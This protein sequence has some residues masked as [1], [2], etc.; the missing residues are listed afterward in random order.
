MD[1]AVAIVQAYLHLNG[2]FTVTEY[3]IIESLTGDNYRMAT[4]IDIMAFRFPGAG[5]QLIGKSARRNQFTTEPELHCPLDVPYMIIAEVKEGHAELNRGATNPKVLGAA[6]SRFGC[7]PADCVDKT[8]KQLLQKG[9]V[10]TPTD[11]QLRLMAFGA[12]G[13][14]QAARNYKVIRL[15]HI[16]RYIREYLHKQWPVLKSAQFKH[17]ALDFFMLL[18]KTLT[19]DDR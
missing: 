11:H 2:Y 17:P 10:H 5:H 19:N 8:V 9:L 6:L 3:P 1:N 14:N 18:E 12:S 7:C 13:S 16:I 15:G 4:D